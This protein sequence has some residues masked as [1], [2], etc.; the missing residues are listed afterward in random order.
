MQSCRK[1]T[2]D[3]KNR[4]FTQPCGAATIETLCLLVE[5]NPRAVEFQRLVIR[6]AR[7]VKGWQRLVAPGEFYLTGGAS[8]ITR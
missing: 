5:G 6:H 3:K 1:M 7:L 4:E 8:Q 2:A